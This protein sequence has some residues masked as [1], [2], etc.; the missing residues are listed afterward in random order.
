MAQIG[1]YAFSGC[2]QIDRV[3]IP[4]GVSLIEECT[5][6]NCTALAAV[7]LPKT[8]KSIGASSFQNCI[9]LKNV[10]IPGG[11]LSVDGFRG[12][13]GLRA[14]DI[15]SGVTAIGDFS[16]CTNLES[17]RLPASLKKVSGGFTD[18][19]KLTTISWPNLADNAV[20]FPAYY[21]T[22]VASRKAAGKCIYCGGDFKLLSKVC[23]VCGK[24]KDY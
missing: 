16:G 7:G 11:V 24:K 3:V 20:S 18:C 19:P 23:K 17:I 13:T 9:S 1:K 15:P 22:V 21:E 10:E 12:C 5:F 6:A 14:L 4:D 8:I 2:E